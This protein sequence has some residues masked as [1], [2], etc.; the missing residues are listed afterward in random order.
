[1]VANKKPQTSDYPPA[2]FN[3]LIPRF[4][5][6]PRFLSYPSSCYSFRTKCH[7]RNVS[8]SFPWK[9]TNDFN[10][11]LPIIVHRFRGD[12]PLVKSAGSRVGPFNK[13]NRRSVR[14]SWHEPS[15]FTTPIVNKRREGGSE[16]D[17][18]ISR[19]A[20]VFLRPMFRGRQFWRCVCVS[21]ALLTS[22]LTCGLV[23]WTE[24]C[25]H[26]RRSDLARRRRARDTCW[27]IPRAC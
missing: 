12:L 6:G 19:P 9:T 5:Q 23:R 4:L 10:V 3:P 16:H 25:A 22:R 26:L 13:R 2:R 18:S 21:Y 8:F 20:D 1:M 15:R 11:A 14:D 7:K 24:L 27:I 17:V